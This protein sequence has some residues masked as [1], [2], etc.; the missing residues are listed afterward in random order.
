MKKKI[1]AIVFLLMLL[2]GLTGCTPLAFQK[3]DDLLRA[4]ALGQGQGEIQKA[5]AETLAE[6][7]QYKFPKE[8]DWRSPLIMADLNG[9]GAE[10][11]V[12][13]YS[14]ASGVAQQEKGNNVYIAILE[15]ADSKWRVTQK[16]EG[17]STEV[18]SLEVVDLLADGTKQLIVGFATANLGSKT[19]SL[20]QYADETLIEMY[21]KPYS[22]YALGD[23]TGRGGTD[24]VLVTPTDSVDKLQLIYLPTV[25]GVLEPP[26]PPIKLYENFASCTGIYPSNGPNGERYLIVDGVLEN[27]I[28]SSQIIAYSGER[29]YML[30]D[31][32]RIIGES[33]R[34]NPLLKAKDIDGDTIVEIPLRIGNNELETIHAD[35]RLEFIEW[36]D[37]TA[38]EPVTKQFGLLDSDRNVY[39]RLPDAWREETIVVDGK[40]PGEWVIQNTSNLS[41][42]V[43]LQVLSAG[44]T[45][46]AGAVHVPGTA[47]TY[48]ILTNNLTGTERD[49]IE[50]F[51]LS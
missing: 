6:E 47:S 11:A 4:P 8:G 40:G 37:F 5:L 28:L 31:S 3:I 20:Y 7:P 10:E 42:L 13:L 46:S 19:F 16:L 38:A 34:I 51:L 24:L 45:P 48:V 49:A 50:L 29:F 30:E 23:F 9:D 43:S 2:V 32:S 27:G 36:K 22:R 18:A 1:G 41:P 14:I 25:N 35:K 39:I 12:L 17:V 44:E 21:S 26:Q 33:G 15:N